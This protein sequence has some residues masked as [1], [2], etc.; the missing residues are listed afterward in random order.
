MEL[1]FGFNDGDM[2][3]AWFISLDLPCEFNA[4]GRT[5]WKLSGWSISAISSHLIWVHTLHHWC[6]GN[7]W[8][9]YIHRFTHAGCVFPLQRSLSYVWLYKD[10]NAWTHVIRKVVRRHLLSNLSS[11]SNSCLAAD[12]VTFELQAAFE[13]H[14]HNSRFKQAFTSQAKECSRDFPGTIKMQQI[15]YICNQIFFQYI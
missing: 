3:Q 12:D 13:L 8:L 2:W 5:P 7:M 9:I 4:F 10:K 6:V 11:V 15:L 1:L 14:H